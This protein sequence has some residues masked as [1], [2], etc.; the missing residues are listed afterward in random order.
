MRFLFVGTLLRFKGVET[1]IDAC[2]RLQPEPARFRAVFIGPAAGQPGEPSIEA[3]ERLAR[4][5]GVDRLAIFLGRRSLA[6]LAA[7]YLA[8]DALL[9][10]TQRDMWPKVLVEAA[11]AGLPLVTTTA[12]GAAGAL[13]K[14]GDTGLVIPPDDPAALAEA[15][16]KLLDPDLRQSLGS[17]AREFVLKFCDP[18]LEA[19]GYV[20]A[21]K[22][23][24]AS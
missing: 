14:D 12:C 24:L 5:K 2:A 20:R 22:K 9:L 18:H 17:K 3:Y 4:Q 1:I 10:P 8:A 23:A 16:R 19:A 13:V 6:E 7:A 15:M 11:L 21:I